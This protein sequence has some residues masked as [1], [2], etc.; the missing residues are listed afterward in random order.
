MSQ[1]EALDYLFRVM[2]E[3][4]ETFGNV[5]RKQIYHKI[6]YDGLRDCK[7]GEI[8]RKEENVRL[9]NLKKMR[10]EQV[11]IFFDQEIENCMIPVQERKKHRVFSIVSKETMQSI[12]DPC[13]LYFSVRTGSYGEFYEGI[14]RYITEHCLNIQGMLSQYYQNDAVVLICDQRD[15][16]EISR[17]VQQEYSDCLSEITPFIPSLNGIGYIRGNYDYMREIAGMIYTYIQFLKSKR[18]SSR[19]I[20]VDYFYEFLKRIAAQKS[21]VDPCISD[22]FF[23]FEMIVLGTFEKKKAKQF[24]Y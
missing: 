5:T 10:S 2:R 20:N 8:L 23:A 11:E 22:M 18:I 15:V 3:E 16:S 13:R 9:K 4:N 12:D 6:R 14:F 1:R 24:F 19:Y 17:Y 21:S 7:P